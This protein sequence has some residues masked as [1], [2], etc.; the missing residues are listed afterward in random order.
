MDKELLKKINLALDKAMSEFSDNEES[1]FH[2][3][4]KDRLKYKY[5]S[6]NSLKKWKEKQTCI[7]E[8]CNKKSIKRS[9]TIQKSGSIKI[10]SEN[11]HVLTPRFNMDNG[12][13]EMISI[14]INE[15]STFPGYCIEHENLFEE[16]ETIK[17]IQTQEHLILQLY[18]TIC[19]EIVVNKNEI[20]SSK[21][22]M[23]QY[24]L[25]RDQQIEKSFIKNLDKDILK[26]PDL[27][28]G[29]LKLEYIDK[30]LMKLDK[31]IKKKEAHLKGF[32]YNFHKDILKSLK[33]KK[34][35]KIV[36]YG[37]DVDREIPIAFAGYGNFNIKLKTKL[38]FVSI[39]INILPFKNKTYIFIATLK[40]FTKE[41]K[42]YKAQ[43]ANHPIKVIDIL[44]N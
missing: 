2:N 26:I 1:I 43:F 37:F 18:R 35:N 28:M 29:K 20:K 30:R 22:L 27:N 44:Q 8:N 34:L 42:A 38:K 39:I 5:N 15:A 32:L 11:N 10:V 3:E 19:R 9:H 40:K 6:I 41:L 7:V 4:E 31:E 25:F 14:G 13:I 16:F 23:E 33:Q 17:D 12:N 24:K 36:Y 21:I